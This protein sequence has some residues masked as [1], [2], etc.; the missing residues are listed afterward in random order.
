MEKMSTSFKLDSL[1]IT[2]AFENPFA[3]PEDMLDESIVS[4]GYESQPG[5]A[6]VAVT[7]D[8]SRTQVIVWEK[9]SRM[10]GY[11]P[12]RGFLTLHAES[13]PSASDGLVEMLDALRGM[14]ENVLALISF[15]EVIM[16][17]RAR[18]HKYPLV[19]LEELF[20]DDFLPVLSDIF[21]RGVSPF[22]I[23][24]CPKDKIES[25]KSLKKVPEWFEL[26]VQPMVE[27]PRYYIVNLVYRDP[28]VENVS[29]FASGLE[30]NMVSLL[31]MIEGEG[32]NVE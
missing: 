21:G 7:P 28:D 27:N 16:N 4:T 29:T 6:V 19:A 9:E 3:L 13:F 17:A 14:E 12:M 5:K 18:G 1:R 2:I 25:K 10:I 24:V 8:G 26:T 23:R 11:D 31:S 15:T 20:S 22:A 30:G 32:E